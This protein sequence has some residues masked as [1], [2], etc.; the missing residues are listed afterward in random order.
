MA[1]ETYNDVVLK[2]Q[3]SGQVFVAANAIISVFL[4]GTSTD[5]AIFE[6]DETTP[7]DNPIAGGA[8]GSF[9]FKANDGFYDIE[10]VFGTTTRRV[11]NILLGA[12]TSLNVGVRLYNNESLR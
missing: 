9:E 5:A 7:K 4:P 11:N 1:M 6:D 3:T 12:P 2:N 10:I 8:D